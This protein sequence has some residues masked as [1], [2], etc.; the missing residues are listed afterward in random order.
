[1][2]N[3]YIFCPSDLSGKT[4]VVT[5]AG[6]RGSG[7][8]NGRAIAFALDKVGA[9]VVLLDSDASALRATVEELSM[10]EESR[11]CAVADV[12]D[13]AAVREVVRKSVE[14]F[15]SIYGLVNNVG[16]SGPPG[17]V[18]QV[19]SESWAVAMKINVESIM[20]CSK[21]VI[22]E[23]R[24]HGSIVNLGSVAGMVGGHHS[25]LYPTSKG[26]V[27]NMTRAMAAHHGR[28]GIRVNCV[29]PGLVYTPMVS[30][31]GMSE[32]MRNTRKARSLLGTEGTAWDVA[33]AA[34]FLLS[35][36]AKWITGVNLPVDAGATAGD[37]SLPVPSNDSNLTP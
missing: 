15:G 20:V 18:T 30:S 16:I 11:I 12:T 37:G 26:A 14:R 31:R 36:A 23:M 35:S 19:D 3:D 2:T 6:S 28:S 1:M 29:S 22:P 27:I 7:V 34:M 33:N 4:V 9:N 21:Y 24:E 13:E 8:G 10:P 17:T 32:S 5:G 25:V